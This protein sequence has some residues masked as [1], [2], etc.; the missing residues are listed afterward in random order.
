MARVTKS[1][2]AERAVIEEMRL[3]HV[4]EVAK[5]DP[6]A[7]IAEMSG[8][9]PT[10]QEYFGFT[11][12]KPDEDPYW[13]YEKPRGYWPHP[14]SDGW[15]WQADMVDWWHT[16][17][18]PKFLMLKARQLG[19]TWLS[20]AYGIWLLL[21][22]P[23][24]AVVC[25]SYDEEQAKKLIQRA[26]LMFNGL[27]EVFR[28]DFEVITPDKAILPSEWIRLRHKP[29]GVLSTMQALPATKKAGHGDTVTWGIMD[30]VARMDYAREIYTAINPATSR[31]GRLCLISTANG[32]SNADSGTGNFFHH[33]Y[34]TKEEKGIAFRFLPWHLHPERGDHGDGGRRQVIEGPGRDPDWYQREAM[35]LPT[36][37]RNQQYP[38]NET[39]A[40]M[41]SGH[42]YFE[43]ED[44][45]FYR[46][47]SMDPIYRGIFEFPNTRK[48]RLHKGDHFPLQVYAEPEPSASY[49][50]GVDVAS[51]TGAD[52]SVI[53]VRD[54][55]NG[56]LVALFLGKVSP[57]DLGDQAYWL[58]RWYN[59]AKIAVERQG[60][61]GEAVIARLRDGYQGRPVYPNLYRHTDSTKGNR[62]ISESYGYPMNVA[63]RPAALAALWKHVRNR[64]DAYLPRDLVSELSTFVYTD[65][66][67]SPRA[68]DG[69]NDD[70]V[71]ADAI[72][73]TLLGKHSP[74]TLAKRS[75][76]RKGYEPLPTRSY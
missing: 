16:S 5:D 3:A 60:G 71:M 49:V 36:V 38:L 64:V 53:S 56:Q 6:K 4:H 30:E 12:W 1:K 68:Q 44:L 52:R 57:S 42:T 34:D 33:L 47:N 14:Q 45:S 46:S 17:E 61:W 18:R 27:P 50:M 23:G 31:G 65:T 24:A 10:A 40:F 19:I 13:P 35:A 67:P 43:T 15:V 32:V 63:T 39:D 51:G 2:A 58:G 28:K 21:M 29:T 54:T 73:V 26:W 74:A 20:V 25:Y 41:L 11:M 76:P 8:F 72:C 59:T 69:C 9:D 55:R 7:L 22:R 70:C 62:P 37:E 75:K 66:K 48:A